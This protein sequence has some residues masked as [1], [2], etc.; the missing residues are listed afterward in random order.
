MANR[1]T[2]ALSPYLRQ[3]AENPVDWWPWCEEAFQEA[4]RRDVPVLLS[5]GYAACHWCHVMAHESFE[6]PATAGLINDQFVPIKVDRE[7]RPDIDAVY[8]AATTALTGSGG[9]PMTVFLDHDARAFFAGTYFP[10]RPRPGMPAFRDVLDALSQAWQTRRD[11]VLDA[12]AGIDQ[13]LSHREAAPVAGAGGE[14]IGPA[15]VA[16]AIEALAGD[17]DPENG[18]FAGAPKFPPAMVVEFLLRADRLLTDSGTPD[19]RAHAMATTT[20]AAMARGG[21]FDQLAGGFARY[22]V[23]ATWVVPHFEKMLYDNALLLGT[24]LHWWRLDGNPLAERIV[25]QTAGFLLRELRTPEGG[26]ASS[27]DADSLVA[28]RRGPAVEGAFY[29]WTPQELQAVLGPEDARWVAAV[30]GVTATGTFERGASVL[31]L[32]HDPDDAERWDRCR[33]ALLGARGSRPRPARDDKIVAE[34]NGLAIGALAEAGTLLGE[35]SW[36]S[37]AQLAAELLASRHWDSAARRLSRVSLAGRAAPAPGVLADYASLAEGLLMLYQCTGEARWLL[38]AQALLT[39]AVRDFGDGTH[40]FFET[41]VDGPALVRRPRGLTDGVTPSGWS[42]TISALTIV[43]ALD[44][45]TGLRSLA[46]SALNRLAPLAR[47]TPRY[48]GW[49]WAAACA[50]L[51]GPWQVGIV[52]A[53]GEL[54]HPGAAAMVRAAR[55]SASPGLV[56]AFG[57]AGQSRPMLLE[58]RLP[59]N[60]QPTAYVC[61]SF[62]CE[63]PTTDPVALRD[64]LDASATGG[65]LA[66]AL[67]H[68]GSA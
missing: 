49:A 27:L 66:T 59:I 43:A 14:P 3:H 23:D 13:E 37:A 62:V 63:L 33:L 60:G 35:P 65:R 54:A 36:V 12:A 31:Q 24:Y 57:E 8:M 51:A 29:V 46:E 30:C 22:S 53:P 42:A 68:P 50:Q 5:V 15:D 47:E 40:G 55:M 6:D 61:R 10:P 16:A 32:R 11:D 18:G 17:F 38:L 41:S 19:P 64:R 44:G 2:D 26:F 4:R 48:T 34:W 52:A 58:H 28:G 9:W 20:L 1:L 39:V 45:D 21:I 67:E 25:R 7:E 56:S